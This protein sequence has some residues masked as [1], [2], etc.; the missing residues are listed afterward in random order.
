L[1][2]DTGIFDSE[3]DFDGYISI[4]LTENHNNLRKIIRIYR[5]PLVCRYVLIPAEISL[6]SG[7]EKALSKSWTLTLAFLGHSLGFSLRNT[8]HA[9]L[10]L[11]TV[12][13]T[14]RPKQSR[15][16]LSVALPYSGS[17][18]ALDDLLPCLKDLYVTA[19][20]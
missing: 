14:I 19:G 5:K 10:A 15:H 1:R 8:L 18:M 3:I 7:F 20:P 9:A 6:W 11:G 13:S 2:N 4:Y 12:N 17:E 16:S